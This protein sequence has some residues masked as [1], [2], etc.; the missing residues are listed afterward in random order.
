MYVY[1]PR[2]RDRIGHLVIHMNSDEITVARWTLP[3]RLVSLLPKVSTACQSYVVAHKPLMSTFFFN[4]PTIAETR[5]FIR[6]R[7][8]R[9]AIVIDFYYIFAKFEGSGTT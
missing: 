5:E 4:I 3:R 6:V 2:V 7:S 1:V 9:I 8:I